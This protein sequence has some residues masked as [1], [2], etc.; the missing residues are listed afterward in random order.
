MM[1]KIKEEGT[2][3]IFLIIPNKIKGLLKSPMK[4]FQNHKL[5]NMF[6]GSINFARVNINKKEKFFVERNGNIW[7]VGI[8]NKY[9]GKSISKAEEF[10]NRLATMRATNIVKTNI[11]QE[12]CS[13]MSTYIKIQLEGIRKKKEVLHFGKVNEGKNKILACSTGRTSLF[14]VHKNILD[15]ILTTPKELQK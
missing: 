10:I 5:V 13:N 3:P 12:E 7:S 1:I 6:L 15:Y 2:S 14:H 11:N 8:K 9:L 4:S